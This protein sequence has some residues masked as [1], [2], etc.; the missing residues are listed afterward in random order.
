M[1][2]SISLFPYQHKYNLS[3]YSLGTLFNTSIKSLCA[4]GEYLPSSYN[5]YNK[6][7]GFILIGNKFTLSILFLKHHS[8]LCIVSF[9]CSSV[10]KNGVPKI[11]LASAPNPN[12][13]INLTLFTN[14]K[15]LRKINNISSTLLAT[16]WSK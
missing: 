5:L 4:T 1:S 2:Y 3:I 7:Y 9:I 16:K 12:D 14:G 6:V 10:V 8:I 11:T 15:G 13:F